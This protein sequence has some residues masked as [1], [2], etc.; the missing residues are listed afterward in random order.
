MQLMAT[1]TNETD[2]PKEWL[3]SSLDEVTSTAIQWWEQWGTTAVVCVAAVVLLAGALRLYG[4]WNARRRRRTV[5]LKPSSKFDPSA[6]EVLRFCGQLTR[7]NSATARIT[8][9]RSTRTVRVRLVH[10][11]EGRMAQ[12]LDA[13][14]GAEQ[15][16]RHRGFAQVELADPDSVRSSPT[17][18]PG[19]ETTPEEE[20]AKP[21]P[22][23]TTPMEP[24]RGLRGDVRR[25]MTPS[26]LISRSGQRSGSIPIMAATWMYLPTIWSGCTPR[27]ND[28]IRSEPVPVGRTR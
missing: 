20:T 6:E 8:V 15:I 7:V 12:L 11:G 10:A 1:Q 19:S 5:L 18:G 25:L 23:T 22:S 26:I 24:G 16:L 17:S 28:Y 3:S 27:S 9:P 4:G 14:I 13:P 21:S 2:T